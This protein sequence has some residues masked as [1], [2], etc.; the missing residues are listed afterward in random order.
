[1]RTIHEHLQA[2]W[3]GM[4]RGLSRVLALAVTLLGLL[5]FTFLLTH[6]APIDPALQIAGDRASEA[7]YLQVRQQLGLDQPLWVQFWH[8][9]AALA[10]G[11]LGISRSTSQPVFDDLTRA[12]PATLELATCAI[13][14][15]FVFGVTLALLSVLKPGSLLDNAVRMFSLVGYSVPIFWLGLL[16][17]LLFYAVLHW[18]G[19]PGRLDD[20]YQYTMEPRTG[21]VLIDT[22][23][24]GDPEMFRNAIRHL[25]LPASVLGLLSMAG[26]T[27]LLRA[28]MLDEYH[29]EYVL[30]ARAKGAGQLRILLC[31]VLPNIRG[32]MVTVLMLSYASLL[33]GA[34]LTET[35]FSWPGVGRYL[36]TALFGADIP[37]ILGST[38][39]IGLCFVLMNALADA[40]IYLTDP[41]T[42]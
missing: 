14:I 17:L 4:G 30:L 13:I 40:L 21:F 28:A 5:L 6:L 41:R 29:K 8:Y 25:W 39:L 42:R 20:I 22:W 19:G 32:V 11:D 9:L 12:F 36:T 37:A 27:R 26:I 2:G 18:A 33:E 24:S 7:T 35:V 10:H 3:Q 34:V 31:H 1:M 16:S 15:G 38:L 23:L